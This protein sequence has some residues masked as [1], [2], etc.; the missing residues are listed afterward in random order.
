MVK[1]KIC[2]ITNVKDAV[3]AA[4]YGADLAG[5]IFIKNTPRY[6]GNRKDIILGMPEGLKKTMS[7]AGLFQNQDVREVAE[8]VIYCSL[9]YV[10][11]QGDESPEYC[12]SLKNI[13]QETKYPYSV[14]IIKAFKVM[15]RIVPV[16]GI[17]DMLG[18]EE[19]ADYFVFDT[20]HP[21][22]GG[23]TGIMF[24]TDILIKERKKI[25]KPF[26]IA[27]GLTPDNVAEIIKRVNPYGVDAS[28]GVENL[29]GEK[30]ETLLKEFITNA[31]NA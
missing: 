30:D 14:K 3:R 15:D 8:T 27:G 11:L 6:I 21:A 5:F 19:C 26:F 16:A 25:R 13:L 29:P 2:G 20:F 7:K 10:Q 24:N 31:K 23:G 22:L 18:Y 17:Y 1:V 9:D 12:G 28:S 4:E